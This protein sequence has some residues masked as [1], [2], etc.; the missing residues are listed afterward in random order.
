MYLEGHQRGQR[1]NGHEDNADANIRIDWHKRAEDNCRHRHD[2]VHG[3]QC[4]DHKTLVLQCSP[5]VARMCLK[6]VARDDEYDPD[7]G[8]KGHKVLHVHDGQ[9]GR[10]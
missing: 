10:R 7:L 1:R 3:N 5:Q 6:A 2:E 9:N 4:P 8:Q